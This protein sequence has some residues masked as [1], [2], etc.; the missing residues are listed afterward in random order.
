MHIVLTDVLTCP[1][2]GPEFGLILLAHHVEAR[3]VSS[4]ALGCSNCREKY[5]IVEGAVRFDGGAGGVGPSRDSAAARGRDAGDRTDR[6]DD[7]TDRV[8]DGTDR[9]DD[10]IDRVDDG[11][12]R[13]DDGIDRVESVGDGIDGDDVV[14]RLGALLGVTHGPGFLLLAGDAVEYAAALARLIEDIEV[15]AVHVGAGAAG[16]VASAIEGSAADAPTSATAG[17]AVA[18]AGEPGVSALLLGAPGRTLPLATGKMAGIALAGDAAD[19][20]L[21]ESIRALSP[22]ARLVL[23]SPP[24][25]VDARLAA[26]R[27]RVLVRDADTLVAARY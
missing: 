20:L 17:R 7:G 10:G 22:V 26:Q 1:R 19:D 13:V 27:L 12:D 6:V 24:A 18:T 11:I 4:G 23:L 5:P 2:C 8:D 9:V 16:G 21:E 25:D 3:R 15:V 14:L